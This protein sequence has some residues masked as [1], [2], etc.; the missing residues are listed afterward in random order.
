[1]LVAA[2]LA[3]LAITQDDI[4][5]ILILSAEI[6]IQIKVSQS[7]NILCILNIQNYSV[8]YI[9]ARHPVIC[10]G[11]FCNHMSKAFA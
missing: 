2:L 4:S 9:N 6:A 8:L 10:E 11:W 3:H 1:L 7:L 5:I